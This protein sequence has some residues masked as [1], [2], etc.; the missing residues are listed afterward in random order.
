MFY[1]R[2]LGTRSKARRRQCAL[3][4][5]QGQK[6]LNLF[7]IFNLIFHLSH[8]RINGVD[9]FALCLSSLA[10]VLACLSLTSQQATVRMNSLFKYFK[11]MFYC[12]FLDAFFKICAIFGD[13]WLPD[14]FLACS[15]FLL[16][17]LFSMIIS[18]N[19]S[20]FFFIIRSRLTCHL[21]SHFSSSLSLPRTDPPLSAAIS[22]VTEPKTNLIC[23]LFHSGDDVCPYS[24]S[25]PLASSSSLSP[26]TTVPS[27]PRRS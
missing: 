6:S 13:S 12:C 23:V 3:S 10:K 24:C 14:E 17:I 25:D 19:K 15:P 22:I 7:L 11:L 9:W 18:L 20:F 4:P 1:L 16:P 5:H 27:S 8:L 26:L 2:S 21:S